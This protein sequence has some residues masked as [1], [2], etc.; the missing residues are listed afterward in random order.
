MSEKHLE[1]IIN[2]FKENG[3]FWFYLHLVER[4]LN[5][6]KRRDVCKDYTSGKVQNSI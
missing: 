1:E 4:V 5:E 3:I 6:A 2:S